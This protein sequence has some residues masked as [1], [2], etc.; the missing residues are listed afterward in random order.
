MFTRV[1]LTML[2]VG[3]MLIP[4]W[5]YLLARWVT[6]PEGF[7]Q[8]FILL[9]AG[10]WFLGLFQVVLL[11]LGLWVLGAIWSSPRIR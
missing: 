10:V 7:W 3:A 5:I 9:G 8:N 2:V 1:F 11:F 4:T 6:N